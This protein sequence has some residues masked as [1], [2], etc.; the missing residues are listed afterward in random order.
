MKF[1]LTN[2]FIVNFEKRCK[3]LV[4]PSSIVEV[5][6]VSFSRIDGDFWSILIGWGPKNG[7]GWHNETLY[8]ED[9]EYSF[10]FLCG[11]FAQLVFMKENEDDD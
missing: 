4:A 1:E 6:E 8:F 11:M 7:A 5:Q 9:K 2:E 3:K 10:D